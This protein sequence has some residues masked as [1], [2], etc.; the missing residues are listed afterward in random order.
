MEKSEER[1][2]FTNEVFISNNIKL[3]QVNYRNI[4]KEKKA[5]NFVTSES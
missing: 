4:Y 1:F 3:K 5:K 2:L